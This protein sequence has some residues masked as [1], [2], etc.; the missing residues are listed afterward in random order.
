MIELKHILKGLRNLVL[1][2][3]MGKILKLKEKIEQSIFVKIAKVL[4]YILVLLLL[5]VTVVQ[6]VTNNSVSVGGY[7][8]F[9]IVSKSMEDEYS[10]GD[11]LVS[12]TVKENELKIGDDITY[13]GKTGE[14]KG[15]IV[16]HQIIKIENEDGVIYY[17][18]KGI[19]NDV[20]DPRIKYDQI[21]GKIVYKTV[22]LSFLGEFMTKPLAYYLIFIVIALVFCIEVVSYIFNRYNE[23]DDDDDDDDEEEEDDDDEKEKKELK[24][25]KEEKELD[26]ETQVSEP[27]DETKDDADGK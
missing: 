25:I 9:M 27:V 8:L 13:L 12:K 26:K 16:T 1:G 2:E 17:T 10:I 15:L 20:A 22:V 21:Y 3:D 5:V 4:L 11:I 23:D 24:E 14:L 6:K 18:T 7:R 19:A